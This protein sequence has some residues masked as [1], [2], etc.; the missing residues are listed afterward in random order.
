V[1]GLY[2]VGFFLLFSLAP[3]PGLIAHQTN[4]LSVLTARRPCSQSQTQVE[5]TRGTPVELQKRALG[6]GDAS[7]AAV[8]R[9]R[10]SRS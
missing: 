4:V 8:T 9:P 5:P 7:W 6:V 3:L 2:V 1:T 10:S